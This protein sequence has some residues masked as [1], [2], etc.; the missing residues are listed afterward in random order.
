MG[1]SSKDW[2]NRQQPSALGRRAERRAAPVEAAEQHARPS[3][4][5]RTRHAQQRLSH[6]AEPPT[7][8][9]AHRYKFDTIHD[10]RPWPQNPET[11]RSP[12]SPTRT[13]SES[14]G[15]RPVA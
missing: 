14:R 9:Q 11:A 1:G 15:A 13:S 6:G 7:I 8:R 5:H 10:G 2:Q 4:G 12:T 3:P